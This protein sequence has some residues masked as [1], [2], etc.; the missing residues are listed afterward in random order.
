MSEKRGHLRTAL[1]DRLERRATR[2]ARATRRVG[3]GSCRVGARARGARRRAYGTSEAYAAARR[4]EGARSRARL[5]SGRSRNRPDQDVEDPDLR[6]AVAA[7]RELPLELAESPGIAIEV[8]LVEPDERDAA[9]PERRRERR[10]V[11]GEVRLDD[12]VEDWD[13][14]RTLSMQR[15]RQLRVAEPFDACEGVQQAS[16]RLPRDRCRRSFERGGRVEAAQGALDRPSPL[17]DRRDLGRGDAGAGSV[18]EPEIALAERRRP[19]GVREVVAGVGLEKPERNF[20]RLLDLDTAAEQS[21]TAWRRRSRS[22]SRR[23]SP[24]RASG[25]GGEG[26][27]ATPPAPPC[28]EAK[29]NPPRAAARAFAACGAFAFPQA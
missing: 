29:G 2:V 28:S 21:A 11:L 6:Q 5:A 20:E 12:A 9:F 25:P 7:A 17:Q 18:R 24:V 22:A 19:R 13:E 14:R 16:Q 26:A 27:R 8:L 15:L 23:H 10:F 3:G 1:I 4:A